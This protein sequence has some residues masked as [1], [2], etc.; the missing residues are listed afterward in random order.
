M[1]Q[2]TPSDGFTVMAA[3]NATG[4]IETFPINNLDGDIAVTNIQYTAS[5]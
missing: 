5:S 2:F 4:G 3:F 1:A